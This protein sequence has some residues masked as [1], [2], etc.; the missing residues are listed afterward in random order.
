MWEDE[1]NKNGGKFVVTIPRKKSSSKYW[2]DTLLAIVGAQFGVPDDEICG[3]VISTRFNKDILSIWT[4]H[5]SHQEYREIIHQK[6]KKIFSLQPS[7]VLEFKSHDLVFKE[8]GISKSQLVRL[9][10]AL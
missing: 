8:E 9:E 5:A 6:L 4:K 3:A 10:L 1:E 7:M 2:E